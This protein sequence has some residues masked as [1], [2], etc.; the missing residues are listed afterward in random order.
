[1]YTLAQTTHVHTL[2][3]VLCYH[4]YLV[5]MIFA[6]MLNLYLVT[7]LMFFSLLFYLP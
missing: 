6:D 3:H 7:F 1:M 5:S 2:S 4:P